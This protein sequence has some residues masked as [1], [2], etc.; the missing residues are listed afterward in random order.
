MEQ[1]T[2]Y[3]RPLMIDDNTYYLPILK[4][5]KSDIDVLKTS[6]GVNRAVVFNEANQLAG[7]IESVVFND[8]I[9]YLKVKINTGTKAGRDLISDFNFIIKNKSGLVFETLVD[10]DA[11]AKVKAIFNTKVNFYLDE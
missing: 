10:K 4:G 7:L 2:S 1:V 9:H 8:D 3:S 6:A 11:I 5:I